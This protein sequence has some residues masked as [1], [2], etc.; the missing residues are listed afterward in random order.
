MRNHLGRLDGRDGFISKLLINFG[1]VVGWGFFFFNR[2]FNS[3]RIPPQMKSYFLMWVTGKLAGSM[4]EQDGRW[5]TE[6]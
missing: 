6:S 5:K 1:Y 3:D 2:F 4:M